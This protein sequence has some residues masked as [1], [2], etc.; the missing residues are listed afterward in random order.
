MLFFKLLT[1]LLVPFAA[2]GVPT[3]IELNKPNGL[4]PNPNNTMTF[5]T[6]VSN[7]VPP[8][9]SGL[10]A[11]AMAREVLFRLGQKARRSPREPSASSPRSDNTTVTPRNSFECKFTM[12]EKNVGLSCTSANLI[13]KR[14]LQAI[15]QSITWKMQ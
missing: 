12:D 5:N 11:R 3:G 7:I 6:T 15:P 9:L 4:N 8:T 1:A 2:S 10:G 13:S 14:I